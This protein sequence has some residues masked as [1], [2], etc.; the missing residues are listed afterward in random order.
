[1]TEIKT[2]EALHEGTIGLPRVLVVH[3]SAI[4]L[5]GL[6]AVADHIRAQGCEPVF[7]TYNPGYVKDV[8]NIDDMDTHNV[9]LEHEVSHLDDI[10][11]YAT[12]P[13][14]KIAMIVS[15]NKVSL[16]QEKKGLFVSN[17][18]YHEYGF[19]IA[20]KLGDLKVKIP[21]AV[22]A[23]GSIDSAEQKNAKESGVVG[24]YSHN[25]VLEP[26]NVFSAVVKAYNQKQQSLGK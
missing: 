12:H 21:V 9:K 26:E 22:L 8:E 17:K 2:D 20:K 24:V 1:M 4:T 14:N 5:D 13:G 11:A 16:G 3:H 18:G 19:E 25:D 15:G 23:G 6:R 10:I 7:M